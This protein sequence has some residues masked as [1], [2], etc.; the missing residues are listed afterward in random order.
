MHAEVVLL[1]F[2]LA[3]HDAPRDTGVGQAEDSA[4]RVG[5]TAEP[6]VP[7][8]VELGDEVVCADPSLRED[9]PV[10]VLA[11]GDWGA[12]TVPPFLTGLS[13]RP[14]ALADLDGDGHLDVLVG[15]SAADLAFRGDGRGGLEA[16][17]WLPVEDEETYGLLPVD[18]DDDGDL[19]LVKA[20]RTG[21]DGLYL[22]EDGAFVRQD[23]LADE[24]YGSTGVA[25]GDL[26][27]DGDLDLLVGGNYGDGGN[28]Y[29]PDDPASSDPADPSRLYLGPTWEQAELS[30]EVHGRA[31]FV[32]GLLPTG[33]IP[34][35][36]F[37]NDYGS[38]MGG[39]QVL[40]RTGSGFSVAENTGAELVMDGMGLAIGEL[41]GDGL[42]DLAV[43]GWGIVRVLRSTDPGGWVEAT[44]ASGLELIDDQIV[45]WGNAFADLDND[46]DEDLLVGF[47]QLDVRIDRRENPEEQ[48]DGVWLQNDGRFSWADWGV[49]FPHKTRGLAVGDVNGDG[50]LDWVS[51]P[52]QGRAELVLSRCGEEAWLVVE[53]DQ[54]A[55]NVDAVGARVRIGDQTRW[56]M[57]GGLSLGSA[58]P[59]PVH[60]G[61]GDADEV[62]LE[63]TWPDGRLSRVA[64]VPTRRRVTVRR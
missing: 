32:A 44:L 9:Q 1:L 3:C 19:D 6:L 52:L 37:V 62:D 5:E 50:W 46:G 53:L 27:G 58:H 60:F 64:S 16:V 45:A 54:P 57:A 20:H 59:L 31:T 33:G 11:E 49:G 35:P 7:V 26:D 36:Y 15:G 13:G 21:R 18:L 55:P 48:P 51:A 30:E 61:L 47:G 22:W 42:P 10:D 40:E 28:Q 39:N 23:T 41:D 2:A 17:A 43:S 12:Q 25:A 24:S 34:S 29:Q 8:E 4:P 56:V 63:I 14:V 38:T